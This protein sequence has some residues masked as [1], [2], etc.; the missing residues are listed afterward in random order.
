VVFVV[1]PLSPTQ[2]RIQFDMF[3]RY[4]K[5]RH[6][7]ARFVF[8]LLCHYAAKIATAILEEDLQSSRTSSAAFNLPNRRPRD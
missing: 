1:T 3:C 6:L 4:G 8:R 7:L 5:H 2:S